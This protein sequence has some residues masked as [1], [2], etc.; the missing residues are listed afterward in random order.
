MAPLRSIP[1]KEDAERQK[2][3]KQK[4]DKELQER[5]TRERAE[6]EKEL[7][8]LE[9]EWSD[10]QP[11]IKSTESTLATLQKENASVRKTLRECLTDMDISKKKADA[12]EQ[13]LTL[14]KTQYEAEN[15]VFNQPEDQKEQTRLKVE[16]EKL[17][18]AVKTIEQDLD[19]KAKTFDVVVKY[20]TRVAGSDGLRLKEEI[21]ETLVTEMRAHIK[22]PRGEGGE[23]NV[24]PLEFKGVRWQSCKLLFPSA[25]NRS[26]TVM[27]E[28][29]KDDIFNK[30]WSDVYKCTLTD[31]DVD[32][33]LETKVPPV[34]T[35]EGDVIQFQSLRILYNGETER[36]H[37]K[38]SLSSK[39]VASELG[40]SF[41]KQ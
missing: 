27:G 9:K 22:Q 21:I 41:R 12:N 15:R 29:R 24:G 11:T 33:F 17:T 34:M 3:N 8:V 23:T 10:M 40:R 25:Q 38:G 7:V 18:K 26:G 30:D 20:E 31:T 16:E 36:L 19:S 1:S 37:L 2:A 6:Q 32:V 5:K 39:R 28:L 14:Y 4:S 13:Q 35:S